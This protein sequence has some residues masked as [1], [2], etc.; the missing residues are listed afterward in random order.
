[1]NEAGI[2]YSQSPAI[3]YFSGMHDIVE[4]VLIQIFIPKAVVKAFDKT[5][6]CWLDKSTFHDVREVPLLQSPAGKLRASIR[7]YRCR[8]AAK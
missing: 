4:S 8:I 5:V 2:C 7:S 3:N 6:L 1:M